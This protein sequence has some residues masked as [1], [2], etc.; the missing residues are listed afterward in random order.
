MFTHAWFTDHHGLDILS[1]PVKH[2]KHGS[3]T[4]RSERRYRSRRGACLCQACAM[5]MRPEVHRVRRCPVIISQTSVSSS[6]VC[7]Y[8]MSWGG[9]NPFMRKGITRGIS[10]TVVGRF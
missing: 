2:F 10:R 3:E 7:Q 4:K 6:K 8:T 1:P 9:G 5:N